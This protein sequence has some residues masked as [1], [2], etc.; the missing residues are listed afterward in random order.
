M[1]RLLAIN[2]CYRPH[3]IIEQAVDLSLQTAAETGAAT[4][5]IRL[6]DL[7]VRP[8]LNCG[9]CLQPACDDVP[10]DCVIR[11]ELLGVIERID[12]ADGFILAAPA[13]FYT[14]YNVFAHFMARLTN[15][16]RRHRATRTEPHARPA[17]L[18]STS[19]MPGLV[20]RLYYSTQPQLRA[21]A[22]ALGATPAGSVYIE[23]IADCDRACLPDKA[24]ERLCTLS[25]K[26]LTG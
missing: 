1:P 26:L 23:M 25:A 24:R 12:A 7:P 15:Y 11:N 14:A 2:G 22:H 10:E 4:D 18:I 20:G 8:C 6:R 3:S 9:R 19:A 17:L 5:I 21:T 13:N 16:A